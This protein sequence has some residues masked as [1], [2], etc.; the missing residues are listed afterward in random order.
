MRTSRLLW[1]IALLA[2]AMA[3]SVYSW[4][5]NTHLAIFDDSVNQS[6][7]TLIKTIIENNLDACHAGLVY[8]DVGI[9]YYYTNFKVYQGLHSYSTVDEMLRIAKN[10]RERAFTYCFKIHLAT[11]GISHNYN[12]P[13]AIRKTHLPNYII[14]PIQELKIEGY[15]LNPVANR[16]MEN[17]KEFDDFV[18]R[19]TGKDWSADAERLNFVIGGGN[20]YTSGFT[21]DTGTWFGKTQAVFYRGL[22][23]IVPA[24][25]S[26]D[27]YRLSV[28]ETLAVLRGQTS[29]LDPSGEYALRAADQ[30][31]MF[32]LYIGTFVLFGLIFFISW[33]KKLIGWHRHE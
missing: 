18:A 28:D 4:G 33:K 30:E 2:I 8:S 24:S 5:P 31:I 12:V 16:L 21:T 25:T 10:D 3:P 9:F 14:H 6:E 20:F 19:A 13:A 15:Y 32:P 1:V 17:H 27:Y 23:A 26:I 22:T 29:N 7:E 11:D